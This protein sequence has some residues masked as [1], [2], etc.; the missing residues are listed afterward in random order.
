[1]RMPPFRAPRLAA[2]VAA[3][4]AVALLFPATALAKLDPHLSA[5]SVPAIVLPNTAF[6][7]TGSIDA[8]ASGPIRLL[9]YQNIRGSWVLQK[10]VSAKISRSTKPAKYAADV[11]LP[12]TGTWRVGASYSGDTTYTSAYTYTNFQVVAPAPTRVTATVNTIAPAPNANVTVTITVWDQLGHRLP[13]ARITST[14]YFKPTKW[15]A[16]AATNASG[17]AQ[18]THNVGAAPAK[19]Y[20]VVV[21]S[22]AHSGGQ[23]GEALTVFRL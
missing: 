10:T 14:W 23:S 16:V 20:Y 1:M 21:D 2:L 13:G 12:Y 5:P 11:T 22:I 3:M 18:I 6:G 9:M 7:V 8:S 4:I 17:V 15:T 19:T